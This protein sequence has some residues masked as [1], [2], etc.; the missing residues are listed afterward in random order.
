MGLL[1]IQHTRWRSVC[2]EFEWN[3]SLWI[4]AWA[5]NGREKLSGASGIAQCASLNP[6]VH[7][8]SPLP[9]HSGSVPHCCP[10]VCGPQLHK[11]LSLSAFHT[12][13]FIRY[14]YWRDVPNIV[15]SQCR[16]QQQSVTLRCGHLKFRTLS[17]SWPRPET[18]PCSYKL[19]W[20]KSHLFGRQ[21]VSFTSLLRSM[22]T[23]SIGTTVNSTVL[24]GWASQSVNQSSIY[25][26]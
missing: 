12:G 13:L 1:H 19:K 26:W 23:Q 3:R 20:L 15:T 8:P 11:L 22:T 9:L 7:F 5:R 10:A 25:C 18:S 6:S 21:T 17:L 4:D 14:R 2:W 24:R 16:L